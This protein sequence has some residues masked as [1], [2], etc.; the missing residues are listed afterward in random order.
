MSNK[1]D[2]LFYAAVILEAADMIDTL[3]KRKKDQSVSNL[4]NQLRDVAATLVDE[5]SDD[6]Q[7]SINLFTKLFNYIKAKL[8]A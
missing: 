5:S 1:D 7:K 3:N 8:G 2:I 6:K 4:A